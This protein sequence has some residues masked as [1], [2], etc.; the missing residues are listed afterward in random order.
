MR[1]QLLGGGDEG[2]ELARVSGAAGQVTTLWVASYRK[3]QKLSLAQ[4]RRPGVEIQVSAELASPRAVRKNPS[5]APLWWLQP[6]LASPG[7]WPHRLTLRLHHHVALL[8]VG[9]SEESKRWE[10]WAWAGSTAKVW[11]RSAKVIGF[12]LGLKASLAQQ[13]LSPVSSCPFFFF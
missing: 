5:L 13:T 11:P 2:I 1:S 9:L 6:P 8:F 3:R 12:L 10:Q 4:F 7:L